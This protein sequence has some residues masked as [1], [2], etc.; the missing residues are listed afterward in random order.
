MKKL[1]SLLLLLSCLLALVACGGGDSEYPEYPNTVMISNLSVVE[2][3]L[4][5]PD[6][7]IVDEQTGMTSAH[8]SE[9][10]STNVSV[11]TYEKT[12]RYSTLAEFW[13]TYESDFAATYGAMQYVVRA[14]AT[15]LGGQDAFRYVYKTTFLGTAYHVDQVV[16][17][18]QDRFYLMTFMT[19]NG[20]EN[21]GAF[22][23]TGSVLSDRDS[24]QVNF[25]FK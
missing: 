11:T 21:V 7:W 8:V 13:T 6:S 18:Y 2:Y 3:Y 4:Y 10:D 14:E 9:L 24:I 12:E 25:A 5:V 22:A 17:M 15:L 19:L 1:I 20:Q 16:T 23:G